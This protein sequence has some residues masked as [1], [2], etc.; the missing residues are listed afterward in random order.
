MRNEKLGHRVSKVVAARII[1]AVNDG[2]DPGLPTER[3]IADEFDVSMTVAREV[4]ALLV[5]MMM[6]RV[7][8]GRRMQLMPQSAWNYL[9]P[10]MLELQDDDG[11]RQLIAELFDL[12][13][14]VEPE[15]AARAADKATA[16]GIARMEELLQRFRSSEHNIAER[17]E[18]DGTF[19]QEIMASTNNRPLAHV[20]DSANELLKFSRVAN[21]SSPAWSADLVDR[22]HSAI[23]D[24]IRARDPEAARTAMREH[25]LWG[26]E[27]IE[28]DAEPAPA[29]TA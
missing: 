25:L 10:V 23:L 19:H 4:V 15:A 16:A 14:L 1:E 13:L 11:K 27:H 7:H 20:L 18:C 5:S 3:E 2:R 6:V 24:A 8:H 22:Q 28:G 26:L 21:E 29:T 12:R 9:H 17:Y